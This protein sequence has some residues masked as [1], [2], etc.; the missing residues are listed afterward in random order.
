MGPRSLYP[1]LLAFLPQEA[2]D[3]EEGF[4]S[5]FDGKD[6]RE[7]QIHAVEKREGVSPG[8][9][10]TVTI[11]FGVEEGELVCRGG[12]KGLLY[13]TEKHRDFTFRFEW[14]Y[15][16]PLGVLKDETRFEGDSGVL[17]FVNEPDKV[18]PKSLA[19]EGSFRE[20]GAIRSMGIKATVKDDA[21]A[22]K[23]ARRP[24]AEWNATEIEVKGDKVAVKLNGAVVGLASGVKAEAGHIAFQNE[25][26]PIHWRNIRIREEK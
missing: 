12:P 4:R 6:L 15:E 25:G 1:L 7:W 8:E 19:V 3:D 17:L 11:P 2:K 20:A 22:R 18:W 24:L 5:L 23:K 16:K 26:H 9:P 13:T 10:I 21:A 14:R